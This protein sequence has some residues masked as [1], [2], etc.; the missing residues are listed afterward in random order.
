M[1]IG[2]EGNAFILEQCT[3]RL[4]S[5]EGETLRQAPVREYDALT[6]YVPGFRIDV[7]GVSH[8]SGST[9]LTNELGDLT[10]C[11]NHA[12]G[13]LAHHVVYAVE[14]SVGV[15]VCL[16]TL[17]FNRYRHCSQVRHPTCAGCLSKEVLREG[18]EG[19]TFVSKV[20]NSPVPSL[21]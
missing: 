12:A 17:T 2:E 13:H 1:P 21:S 19:A 3:L 20:F 7:Q 18:R 16:V 6:R 5:A 14:E 15:P 11:G 8:V 10:I 9:G 4:G